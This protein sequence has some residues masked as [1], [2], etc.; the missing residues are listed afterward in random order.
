[1]IGPWIVLTTLL[2]VLRTGWSDDRDCKY[3]HRSILTLPEGADRTQLDAAIRSARNIGFTKIEVLRELNMATGCAPPPNSTMHRSSS[4]AHFQRVE[5]DRQ[6]DVSSRSWALDRL[7]QRN[8]PLDHRVFDPSNCTVHHGAIVDAYV[9]DTGCDIDHNVFKNR[10]I[11]RMSLRPKKFGSGQDDNGHGTRIASLLIGEGTGVAR[12]MRVICI[13]ALTASGT[14]LFS[15]VIAAMNYAVQETILKRKTEQKRT[16]NLTATPMRN[17]DGAFIILS[18]AGLAVNRTSIDTAIERVHRRGLVTFAAAGNE[19]RN[20]CDYTPGRGGIG[21]GAVGRGDKVSGF[22]NWGRCVEAVGPG[23]GVLAAEKGGRGTRIKRVSGTS[24]STPLIAGLV[25]LMWEGGHGRAVDEARRIIAKG[26]RVDGYWMPTLEGDVCAG[27]VL[28]GEGGEMWWGAGGV[29]LM[30]GMLWVVAWMTWGRSS[31]A[32]AKKGPE[33]R[34]D[35]Q[36]SSER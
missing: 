26:V 9:I 32:M 36:L 27:E 14:G 15:D 31:H 6:I 19:G 1:M 17:K 8:L 11:R 5:M 13:K 34:R 12:G 33:G 25:A 7:D 18:M 3:G 16:R 10:K 29:A 35:S 22:S 23:Q 21:I 24:Y 2:A 4:D 20:A 28:R 30:L